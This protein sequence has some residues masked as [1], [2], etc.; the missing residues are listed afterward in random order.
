[1][2]RLTIFLATLHWIT[3]WIYYSLQNA[4]NFSTALAQI[5]MNNKDNFGYPSLAALVVIFITSLD[6]IRRHKYEVFFYLHYFFI[7]FYLFG[8]LHSNEM[9]V[10]TIIAAILYV[11]DKVIQI[12]YGTFPMK[13]LMIKSKPGDLVQIIFGKHYVARLLNLHKVGQYM[14]VNFPSIN[15]LEWHPFSVSSGPDETTVEIHVKALGDHTR[16]LVDF[17]KTSPQMWIRTDGPYGNLK[18]NYRRFPIFVLTAGGVGVTPVI[19]I[20]KDIFRYGQL[21]PKAKR[22]H[23]NFLEKVFLLWTVST[24]DQFFWFEEEIR[25]FLDHS[26]KNGMPQLEVRVFMTKE[27]IDDPLVIRG[28]P[29]YDS[30]FA[31]LTNDERLL[32][33]FALVFACGP[34]KM[35]NMCWD[36][37]SDQQREG[38]AI[39]FHHETFEF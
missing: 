15:K 22:Q 39:H 11:L 20:L 16:K 21:D 31:R 35:V 19:G 33:K 32:D 26:L 36:A 29:E 14:F 6:W 3:A 34:R 2:G 28:R 8:L 24:P 30:F 25:W 18:L 27:V 9:L 38:A 13:T 5:S 17:A 23:K 10:Y 12:I 4:N 1:L 7:I 37:V